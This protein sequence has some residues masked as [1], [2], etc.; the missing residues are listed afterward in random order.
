[1]VYSGIFWNTVNIPE[2]SEKEEQLSG[3]EIFKGRGRRR[4]V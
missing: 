2:Y 3:V 4:K 1:L